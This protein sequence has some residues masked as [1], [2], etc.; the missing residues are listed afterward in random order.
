M[1][2]GFRVIPRQLPP[3]TTRAI[4]LL[5]SGTRPWVLKCL[6]HRK[7]KL[8]P[9]CAPSICARVQK[10]CKRDVVVNTSEHAHLSLQ[11]YSFQHT[12]SHTPG[13]VMDEHKLTGRLQRF[14]KYGIVMGE[15]ETS[16]E[17]A[18]NA[19][20]VYAQSLGR[21]SVSASLPSSPSSI[22][23]RLPT[24]SPS[25]PTSQPACTP[26]PCVGVVGACACA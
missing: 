5:P 18:I 1:W 7:L 11:T 19:I 10:R 16:A 9:A 22:P 26:L 25:L 4:L 12:R 14:V 13:Q 24:M 21:Y 3:A 20:N 17:D 23:A 2:A 6:H 8:A 15:S